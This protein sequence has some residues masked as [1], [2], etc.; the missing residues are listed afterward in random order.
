MDIFLNQAVES[1]SHFALIMCDI[2]NFKT[3]NDTYGHDFGDAVLKG[4]NAVIFS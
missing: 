1:E 2:D 4:I 3:V